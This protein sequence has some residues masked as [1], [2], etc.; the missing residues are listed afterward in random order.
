MTLPANSPPAQPSDRFFPLAPMFW[1]AMLLLGRY[2][3]LVYPVFVYFILD[4]IIRSM[5][6]WNA[7]AHPAWWIV[8]IGMFCIF[9]LFAAGWNGMIFQALKE[10]EQLR[11]QVAAAN[12]WP[13]EIKRIPFGLL[14]QFIPHLGQHG[15]RFLIGALLWGV[16][17]ILPL[18]GL[19]AVGMAVVGVPPEMKEI[20]SL[21]MRSEAPAVAEI[22]T[23]LAGLSAQAQWRIAQWNLLA[24]AAMLLMFL[25]AWLTMFWQQHLY[26]SDVNPAK[27]L[28]RSARTVL[29][30]PFKTLLIILANSAFW[31]T[32]SVLAAVSSLFIFLGPFLWILGII[33]FD[34]LKYLY[35]VR[36][37]AR[38]SQTA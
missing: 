27:A 29:K 21:M 5:S 31:M 15:P 33:Y 22:N 12:T 7:V 14:K 24:I 38:L 17:N 1:E 19:V 2:F 9:N 3:V 28:W 8:N 11:Q 13:E 36:S 10:W 30:S 35:V 20:F 23:L 16:L 34:L 18:A 37:E 25:V 6:Q 26:V 4:S 32:L